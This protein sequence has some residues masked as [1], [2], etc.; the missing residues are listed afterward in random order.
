VDGESQR[1]ALFQAGRLPGIS[2]LWWQDV[3]V[4]VALCAELS[5]VTHRVAPAVSG[6]PYYML[7]LGIA[8][9]H[10]VLA[11][12]E[13]GLGT[14]WI[15]WFK[16]RAV[17]RILRVPRAVR[18]V[19]LLAVGYPAG[20]PAGPGPRREATEFVHWNSRWSAE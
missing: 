18:V 15:G 12:T 17:K 20:E 16:E 3:P 8:G 14:C 19:A 10:F 7:D 11:A 2:H 9:E 13:R 1:R 5:L 6:I 4:F